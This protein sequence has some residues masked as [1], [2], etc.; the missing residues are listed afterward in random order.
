MQDTELVE[1]PK[2]T[3]PKDDAEIRRNDK[4]SHIVVNPE[5]TTLDDDFDIPR[6]DEVSLVEH[7][8]LKDM[9]LLSISMG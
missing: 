9:L 8:N 3:T 1:N 5:V 6:N 7:P 4:V 2:I